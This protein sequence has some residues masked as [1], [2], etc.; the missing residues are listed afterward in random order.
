MR[1]YTESTSFVS[2]KTDLHR[3]VEKLV[4]ICE[5]LVEENKN[6]QRK[7]NKNIKILNLLHDK[8]LIMEQQIECLKGYI[9]IHRSYIKEIWSWLYLRRFFHLI[10]NIKNGIKK[11]LLKIIS[12]I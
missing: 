6:L 9:D 2:N 4:D 1:S 3:D 7:L 10:L 5:S 8:E 11:I 12:R